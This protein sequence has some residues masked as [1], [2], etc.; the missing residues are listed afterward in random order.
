MQL[1]RGRQHQLLRRGGLPYR[2][3]LC[4]PLQVRRSMGCAPIR[5][6]PGNTVSA[7]PI[8]ASSGAQNR[9]DIA[10]ALPGLW[11]MHIG[12]ARPG[13]PDLPRQT[14]AQPTPAKGSG[15]LPHRT[16]AEHPRRQTGPSLQQ[17]CHS[18]AAH[19]FWQ[20]APWPCCIKA[21]PPVTIKL[22]PIEK[23][24]FL[25]Q[26]LHPGDDALP[27]VMQSGCI[28]CKTYPTVCKTGDE[29][30]PAWQK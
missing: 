24:P 8:R 10:S 25:Q 12:M 22:P 14:A 18:R 9:M 6:P 17:R 30:D 28:I 13:S 27:P 5:H 15:R 19:C 3:H 29:C 1:R 21:V 20:Q 26:P 4:Q 23:P 7:R 11:A 2:P 16:G